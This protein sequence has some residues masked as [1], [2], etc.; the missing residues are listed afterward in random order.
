MSNAGAW[1]AADDINAV[2][3]RYA[4]V[5]LALGQHD[6]DYVDAFYGPAEWKTQAEKEKKS[7]DA[8][9]A[10][11]AELLKKLSVESTAAPLV[12]SS[13]AGNSGNEMLKLRREY[14]QKQISAL[15]ARVRILKGEKVKFDDESR[16]LYDAVAP[17][18]EDSHFDEIIK[19]VEAK[20]PGEGPLWKRYE[21]WRKPFVIP[22]EKLDAVFQAAIKECRARTLAHVA[23]PPNESFTVEYVTNKPWGGYNWYKGNF[24]SV[25]QVNTD[26]PTYIDRAVDLAA[27]EGYPG[28]HVY[29]SLLEKNLVRDRGWVEFSVY[30][31]FSPQSLVAEGTANF[32]RDVAFPTKTE[33]M[34]FEKEVL[35][36]A[37]G[38]DS[39]RADE[40]YAVQDL[41]KQLDYAVNE[42]ARR[43]I[44]G[45]ID[46]NAA[47]QWLQKYAVMDPARAQQR[48][49][50]IRRYRS[51]VINYNLGEDMVRSYIE[52]RSDVDLAKRWKEFGKLL[53]SPR[54]PSGIQN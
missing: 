37:A 30:P 44:N 43:L 50:F 45:E 35:F 12:E 14:L 21:E 1:A 17:T 47:V 19:Q 5:V 11:A 23:L 4:H 27:H 51:Y 2:A 6:P 53:S 9:G 28:H 48:V 15:A 34:K 3:E 31:L 29:N 36:P 13:D 18:Y 33:R 16:A 39:K 46:E 7:L 20:I 42:A 54:L 41:M 10:E 24:Q 40:Y 22:K 38:I 26:L 32:G 25:I 52:K 49:K 8:I